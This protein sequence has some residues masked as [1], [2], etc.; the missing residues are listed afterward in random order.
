MDDSIA[1]KPYTDENDIIC[2]HY[3]HSLQRNVKSLNFVTCIYHSA[4]ISL[5]VGF[6]LIAKTEHYSDLKDGKEKRR[7]LKIKN[8]YYREMTQQAVNNQILFKYVL[9]DVWFSAADNMVFVKITL[10]KDFVMPFKNN[11]KMAVS[12]SASR[13]LKSKLYLQAIQSAYAMLRE[14]NPVSLAAC[15]ELLNEFWLE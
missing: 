12:L 8:E 1:E 9:N 15:G 10:K 13:A 11:R 7:S 14:L 5:P 4:G 3:D 6:E 2:W